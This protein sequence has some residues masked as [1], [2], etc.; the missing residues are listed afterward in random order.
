M[1]DL[2]STQSRVTQEALSGRLPILGGERVYNGYLPF[3][4]TC[5]AFSA[6]TWAFL[7]GSY[8][9]YIGNTVAGIAGYTTGMIL[10][11]VPVTLAAG[12]SSYR[13][14]VETLDA[15]KEG[16]FRPLGHRRPDDRPDRHPGR[17]DIRGRGTY[18]TRRRQCVSAGARL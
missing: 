1:G 11:M 17:L 10:G 3:L 4:W 2:K 16:S 5:V 14:G 12:F 13:Y 7:I 8:L 6:A 15:A 9:P 18:R